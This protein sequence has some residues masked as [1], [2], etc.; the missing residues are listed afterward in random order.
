[1]RKSQVTVFIVLGIVLLIV[2]GGLFFLV[3][4][5]AMMKANKEADKVMEHL[6]STTAI[7]TY[8]TTCLKDAS[9]KSIKLAAAQGGVIYASQFPTEGDPALPTGG[10]FRLNYILDRDGFEVSAFYFKYILPYKIEYPNPR[11]PDE[12]ITELQQIPFGIGKRT[13]DTRVIKTETPDYPYV[14]ASGEMIHLDEDIASDVTYLSPLSGSYTSVSTVNK[15]IPLCSTTGLN[16]EYIPNLR[17]AE[18]SCNGSYSNTRSSV[19]DYLQDYIGHSVKHCVEFEEFAHILGYNIEEGNATANVTFGDNDIE[20]ILDYP[21]IMHIAGRHPLTRILKFNK[22]LD[23][24]FKKLYFS[25]LRTAREDSNNIFFDIPEDARESQTCHSS[26]S[27]SNEGGEDARG[28]P[29]DCLE[30]GMTIEKIRAPCLLGSPPERCNLEDDE[31]HQEFDEPH[32]RFTD[33]IKITDTYSLVEGKPLVLQF[34]VENR[35][36]A[37]DFIHDD[38]YFPNVDLAVVEGDPIIINARGFDP[39]E[40]NHW[41]DDVEGDRLMTGRYTFGDINIPGVSWKEWYNEWFDI[42]C[43]QEYNGDADAPL[44][45]EE[46]EACMLSEEDVNGRQDIRDIIEVYFENFFNIRN[47]WSDSVAVEGGN[48]RTAQ[49]TTFDPTDI[50]PDEFADAFGDDTP[51]PHPDLGPHTVRVKVCDHEGVNRPASGYCDYQDVKILI[52]DIPTAKIKPRQVYEGLPDGITSIEDPTLLDASESVLV[53]DFGA[54]LHYAWSD[55]ADEDNVLTALYDGDEEIVVVPATLDIDAIVGQDDKF[56]NI[57]SPFPELIGIDEWYGQHMVR[58][59]AQGAH[60]SSGTAEETFYVFECLPYQNQDNNGKDLAPYPYTYLSNEDFGAFTDSYRFWP[61]DQERV[62]EVDEENEITIPAYYSAT[63]VCCNGVGDRLENFPTTITENWGTVYEGGQSCFDYTSYGSAFSFNDWLF[64]DDDVFVDYNPIFYDFYWQYVD[65]GPRRGLGALGTFG[66]NPPFIDGDDYSHV[67]A[68]DIYSRAFVRSCDGTRGNVCSGEVFEMRETAEEGECPDFEPG[69]YQDERCWG[70]PEEFAEEDSVE[71]HEAPICVNYEVDGDG[72]GRTFESIFSDGT[73]HCDYQPRCADQNMNTFSGD[74]PLACTAFCGSDGD[75][76]LPD[77]DSCLC[78]MDCDN[79]IPIRCDN[80]PQGHSWSETTGDGDKHEW[81]CQ[82]DCMSTECTPHI[83]NAEADSPA[84]KT[85][86]RS[87]DDCDDEFWLD[88]DAPADRCIKC[89]EDNVERW[90]DTDNNFCE[91]VGPDCN[92]DE[93]CD[94]LRPDSIVCDYDIRT[95]IG[96]CSDSC[97]YSSYFFGAQV[98]DADN[99]DAH[100][101]CHEIMPDSPVCNGDMIREGECSDVCG[102]DAAGQGTCEEDCGAAES[103][104]GRLPNSIDNSGWCYGIDSCGSFCDFSANRGWV[105]GINRDGMPGPGDACIT[106]E[107]CTGIRYRERACRF[108]GVE[109]IC[110]PD[111]CERGGGEIH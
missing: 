60:G 48:G 90:G 50:N 4:A 2:F 79:N 23:I 88:D 13:R 93:Q 100:L 104:D 68:N 33:I 74:G 80:H 102:F 75:C 15:L 69:D 45:S 51:I 87:H 31:M 14:G 7:N 38:S 91:S 84:C 106:A 107:Q 98:C 9:E 17:E 28:V 11:D 57:L 24:R 35:K 86:A 37:L 59:D 99:C 5:V 89:D 56:Q 63:H 52:V 42:S 64:N 78:E 109:G 92:A 65:M 18:D 83:F 41:P 3:N 72:H 19:Q 27:S 6:A 39:D 103:C 1:M 46:P 76:D 85:S 44:C 30:E 82:N 36:P 94:E 20:V 12:T 111:G 26:V 101:D 95:R 22:R 54:G 29:A 58:L 21:V 71:V 97:S 34:A 8:I 40:D 10:R 73:G 70:P 62:W 67:A 110:T 32:D 61:E 108:E 47:M 25:A 55:M 49:F 66:G 53:F 77:D 81:G 43:C 105:D 96:T 16:A